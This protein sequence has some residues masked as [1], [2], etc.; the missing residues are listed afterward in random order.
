MDYN[1]V[2]KSLNGLSNQEF[3]DK[4]AESY[5]ISG[6]LE[7]SDDPH[8]TKK[9]EC[10]LYLDHKWYKLTVKQE[11]ID[12]TNL[13]KQLDSQILTDL[14]LSPILG[15]T[16]LR[17]DDRID[18]VGGIRGLEGLVKRCQEDSIAAFAMYPV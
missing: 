11:K 10:S 5:D 8:P 4:I 12:S 13:I 14:I 9:N 16:D 18:F 2:L 3:L 6:P 7:E 15:I 17:S 1:R